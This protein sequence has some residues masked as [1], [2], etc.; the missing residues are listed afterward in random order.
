MT[1]PCTVCAHPAV[2]AIDRALVAGEPAEKFARY[3]S[4]S[5]AAVKR[6]RAEHLPETLVKAKDAEDL[7]H[8]VDV[9]KQLRAINA[10]SLQIL[11]EARLSGNGELVLKAVDRVQRQVELQ[12]KLLGDLDDRPAVSILVSPEWA[13]VR[14]TLLTALAPHPA[15]RADVSVALLALE[16]GESTNGHRR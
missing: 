3:R 11:N 2:E 4:L 12:A 1:R 13:A 9:V 14:T 6:H 8:A 5:P 15:A 10:A 7:G 16:Q